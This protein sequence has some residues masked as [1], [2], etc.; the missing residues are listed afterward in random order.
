MT[1]VVF[2]PNWIGDVAMATPAIR[3][4]RNHF[5]AERLIGVMRPHLQ[6][7]LGGNPWFDEV[8]TCES[9]WNGGARWALGPC[10][11]HA[12]RALRYGDSPAQLFSDGD[13]GLVGRGKAACGLRPRRT[14]PVADQAIAARSKVHGGSISRPWSTTTCVW[15]KR[16]DV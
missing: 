10:A 2:L 3:A 14:Q 1:I 7:L 11:S 13:S 4:L 16:S 9:R 12:P 8:W 6:G 5:T 15:P